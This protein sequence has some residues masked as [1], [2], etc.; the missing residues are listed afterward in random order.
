MR[1][2]LLAALALAIMPVR[3]P[4]QLSLRV[5]AGATLGSTL[6]SKAVL[7]DDV[8]TLSSATATT[9]TVALGYP[10]A[11]R[12]RL[13]L[14]G[15][16]ARG[17]LSAESNAGVNDLGSLRTIGVVVLAEGPLPYHLRFQ[18]GGGA[19]KY[20]PSSKSGVFADDAP[21]KPMVAAGLGWTHPLG[22][23]L[24]LHVG[25][26]WDLHEFTTGTLQ[27]RGWS[28]AQRVHRLSLTVGVERGF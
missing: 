18:L 10:I 4:A 6:V 16:I 27:R 3:A 9:L 25:G 13:L 11:P 21:I 5:G 22:R 28:L 17:G 7:Y 26:R 15:R 8:V 1:F 19:M 20:S 2:S 14:E 24:D 12:Y 23:G